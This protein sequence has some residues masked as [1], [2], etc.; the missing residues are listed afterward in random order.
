MRPALS[1][2][3]IALAAGLAATAAAA[4]SLSPMTN[5]GTTPSD[6]KGFRL[7]VGNPYK[8]KMV[9]VV[10]PMDPRF[11]IAAEDAMVNFPELTMAP[12]MSRQV[13]V[14]FRI[15]AQHKERTIGVCVWPKQVDGPILPRVC[16]RYTGKRLVAGG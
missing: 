8:Q 6:V 7:L 3:A 9:F 10:V 11:E 16:G 5:S 1:L 15:D 2:L 12:G 13:I 4:Q 14:T